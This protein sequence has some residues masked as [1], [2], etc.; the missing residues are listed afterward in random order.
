VADL[1]CLQNRQHSVRKTE[2]DFTQPVQRRS[3]ECTS[4][5]QDRTAGKNSLGS[6][7]F[8][9]SRNIIVR[10]ARRRMNVDQMTQMATRWCEDIFVLDHADMH[11]IAG[12]LADTLH[13]MNDAIVEQGGR[14]VPIPEV[15]GWS[16]DPSSQH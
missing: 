1:G 14:A 9:Y 3:V 10:S 2:T 4:L 7:R 5:S 15:E 16:S 8:G 11:Q 13:S 12:C 6:R